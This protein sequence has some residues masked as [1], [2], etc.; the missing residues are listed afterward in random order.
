MKYIQR[1]IDV[2]DVLFYRGDISDE[3]NY[4]ENLCKNTL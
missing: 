2:H 4:S 1:E 3:A